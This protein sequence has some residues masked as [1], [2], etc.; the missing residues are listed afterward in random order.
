MPTRDLIASNAESPSLR[1]GSGMRRELKRPQTILRARRSRLLSSLVD[2]CC[3]GSCL[4]PTQP[5]RGYPALP[6]IAIPLRRLYDASACRSV[7]PLT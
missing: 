1:R 5:G 6:G 4:V 7:I 3:S 2:G